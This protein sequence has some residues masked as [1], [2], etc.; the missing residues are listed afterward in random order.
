MQLHLI[1]AFF[2][3]IL[4]WYNKK[5]VITLKIYTYIYFNIEIINYIN[6]TNYIYAII[7]HLQNFL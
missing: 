1:C 6:Y 3:I 4:I 2:I 7:F 5:L